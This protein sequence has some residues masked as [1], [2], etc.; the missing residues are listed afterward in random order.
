[1]NQRFQGLVY[2]VLVI[3]ILLLRFHAQVVSGD[4]SNDSKI[5]S[6]MNHLHGENYAS[7]LNQFEKEALEKIRPEGYQFLLVTWQSV[8]LI[9]DIIYNDHLADSMTVD[10]SSI[11]PFDIVVLDHR[12]YKAW[13]DNV[14]PRITADFILVTKGNWVDEFNN[15][16]EMRVSNYS[17]SILANEHVLHWFAQSPVYIESVTPKYSAFPYGIQ[18]FPDRLLGYADS[19]LS[20]NGTKSDSKTIRRYHVSINHGSRQPFKSGGV[21]TP[22]IPYERYLDYLKVDKFIM[23]PRGDIPE[24]YRYYEAIGFDVVPVSNIDKLH[25]FPIFGNSMIYEPDSHSMMKVLKSE[26]LQEVITQQYKP[27]DRRIVSSVYWLGKI[28]KL[29][30]QL[31]RLHSA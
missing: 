10:T 13:V 6:I 16:F 9:K 25:Y 15:D 30:D 4:D 2:I 11:K 28:L 7:K 17:K 3:R 31:K 27:P 23:A 19:L 22:S 12:F 8:T 18:P 26:W 29:R 14:L 24:T 21:N 1:M 5:S 20:Y